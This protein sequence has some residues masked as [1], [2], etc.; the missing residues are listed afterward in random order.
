MKLY[1]IRHSVREV[2][3]DFSEAEEGDPEAELTPEGE[4]IATSL[5]EWMADNDEIPSKLIVS[6]TVRAQQTAEHIADAIREAGFAPP[7][8]K[9]DVS[10]GPQ[11]SIRGLV[12]KLAADKDSKG[13]GIISHRASIVQ[14]L[15]QLGI[16]NNDRS[17]VDDPA[18]GE[19]RIVKVKRGSG[20]W[21]EKRRVRPSDMGRGFA[22][23]Y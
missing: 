12:Q 5:G 11:Q 6:P 1:L 2:P 13:V 21:Q 20:R 19:A 17:K 22:D 9:T 3:E 4:E 7:D 15:K 23:T 18:M 16:D 14:G 10:I 8:I